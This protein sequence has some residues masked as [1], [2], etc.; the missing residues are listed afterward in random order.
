MPCFTADYL[1]QGHVPASSMIVLVKVIDHIFSTVVE[2]NHHE[3]IEGV[4]QGLAVVALVD[5]LDLEDLAEPAQCG[6]LAER[7]SQVFFSSV[8]VDAPHVKL[9]L[10]L[11]S[12][13]AP[14]V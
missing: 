12:P 14:R 1:G 11:R 5:N 7:F 2:P 3:G 8:C 13:P 4:S 10:R 6:L 9:G